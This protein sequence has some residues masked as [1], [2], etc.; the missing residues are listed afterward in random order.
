MSGFTEVVKELLETHGIIGD[1]FTREC[2]G[3]DLVE[4]ARN[5][6]KDF[7][8][9]KILNTEAECAA[10]VNVSQNGSQIYLDRTFIT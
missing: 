3:F 6:L 4:G 10:A 2:D 5:S 1:Y 8:S 7:I 9:G